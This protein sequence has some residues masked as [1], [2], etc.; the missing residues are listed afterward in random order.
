VIKLNNF[1]NYV[2]DLEI[3]KVKKK[4]IILFLKDGRN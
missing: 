4:I 2:N 1:Y 3:S